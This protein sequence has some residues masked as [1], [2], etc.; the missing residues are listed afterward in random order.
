MG[1]PIARDI[2]GDYGLAT[3]D[4]RHR[5]VFNGIYSPGLG[6][7]VSGLYFYGSGARFATRYGSD[8]RDVGFGGMATQRLRPDGSIIRRNNFVGLPLHRVDM[9]VQKSITLGRRSISGTVDVFNLLN[10]ANYGSYTLTETSAA[11]TKPS[12]NSNLA[13]QARMVQF[14]FRLA[15]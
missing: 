5:A 6:I 9:R 8:V 15:F 1:F 12:Y 11:Y 2:A 4:Q 7:Q 13:Y 3:T 14:G 10:R